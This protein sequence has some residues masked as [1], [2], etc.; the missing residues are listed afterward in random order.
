[1][2]ATVGLK[3]GSLMSARNLCLSLISPSHSV[4]TNRLETKA[5]RADASRFTWA[6]FH[7][8][9][10]TSSLLSRGSACWAASPSEPRASRRQQQIVARFIPVHAR[11]HPYVGRTFQNDSSTDDGQ[12]IEMHP[13]AVTNVTENRTSG[14]GPQTL[15]P[16][17]LLGLV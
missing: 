10:R 4:F 9:S 14:V 13:G 15:A 11:R 3:R 12:A 16:R 2:L 17:E 8:R 5:S 1:M 6:S 7:R